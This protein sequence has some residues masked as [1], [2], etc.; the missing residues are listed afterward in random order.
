MNKPIYTKHDVDNNMDLTYQLHALE[1]MFTNTLCP[2]LKNVTNYTQL[3]E[4][5]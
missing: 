1:V 5:T 3:L 2:T 4:F